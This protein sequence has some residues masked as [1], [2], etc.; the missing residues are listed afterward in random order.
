M[1]C[2]AGQ[3]LSYPDSYLALDVC[4]L[5]L[6]AAFEILRVYWGKLALPKLLDMINKY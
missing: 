1:L 4:L 3:V 2:N 5:L 6:L